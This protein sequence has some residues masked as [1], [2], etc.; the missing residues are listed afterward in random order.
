MYHKDLRILG[1]PVSLTVR[2]P[3]LPASEE[4]RGKVEAILREAGVLQ[5]R[6]ADQSTSTM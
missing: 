1:R 4:A 6:E 5:A 2:G 3:A